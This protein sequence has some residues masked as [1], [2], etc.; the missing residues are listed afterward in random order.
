MNSNVRPAVPEDREELWRLF[1]LLHSENAMCSI[2][3]PKVEYHLNRFIDPSSIAP[4]DTGPRGFIGVV[5]PV[6]ALEGAIMVVITT[7]W[8]SDDL[9]IEE[10]FNFVDPRHRSSNHAVALIEYA[11]RLV[12]D[13]RSVYP[14]LRLVIGILS[15]ERIAAKMR[16]YAQKL[17]FAGGFFV[18]P[19]LPQASSELLGLMNIR[20]RKDGV[21]PVPPY[22]GR[23]H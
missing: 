6:G 18:Y 16:L 7:Q 10:Y 3:E 11:K 23:G 5:G 20:V 19:P 4:D 2:S 21:T 13:N 9:L 8:Y 12:D 14:T 15:F 22:H 17:P 1:R